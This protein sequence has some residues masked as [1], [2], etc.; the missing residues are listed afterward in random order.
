M[1]WDARAKAVYYRTYSRPKDDAGTEFENWDE[2]VG[3]SVVKHHTRL[4]TEAG[5]KPNLEEI[6][7][8][9]EL[10]GERKTLVSGRTLWLGGTDYSANRACSQ[11][12]CSFSVV[13]S[14]YSLVDACWLL[15]NGCLPPETPL[16]TRSGPKPIGDVIVGEEVLSYNY[17][18]DNYEFKPVTATHDVEVPQE[19]NIRLRCRYGQ[20]TTSV[21]HPILVRR[22]GVWKYAHAADLRVGDILRKVGFNGEVAL[23]LKAWF[24]GAFLGD[25]CS[26][27]TDI[28]SRRIRI[29]DDNEGVVK[30]FAEFIRQYSG[31]D[32]PVGTAER[33]DYQVPMWQVQKT[34]PQGNRLHTDWD[35]IVG[36]LPSRKTFVTAVPDWVKSSYDP[37]VFFSFLAG[38]LD[39]D[40]DIHKSK[41]QLST[42]SKTLAHDLLQLCPVFGIYPWLSEIDPQ[43]YTSSGYKPL[44]TMYRLV[45]TTNDVACWA[46]LA[47]N[48]KN[49]K[50]IEDYLATKARVRKDVVIPSDLIERELGYLEL[51][52]SQRHNFRYQVENN[53]SCETGY[54]VSRN[55]S[56]DHMAQFDQVVSIERDLDVPTT[57]KDLTVADNHSYVCGDGSYYVMHNCGYGFI[58]RPGTLHGF[59]RPIPNI[60]FVESTRD[61]ETKGRPNNIEIHPTADNGHAWYI[62]IGDS[63]EAWAKAIGKLFNPP[64]SVVNKLTID[65]SEIRGPGKRLKGYGWIC[66]GWQP[67]LKAIRKMVEILNN[68]AGDLLTEIDILDVV[69]HVGTILS[70]RRSAQIALLD[71]GHPRW[72]EFASAKKDFWEHDNHHRQQSNNSLVLWRKPPKAEIRK[73]M[74]MIWDNGGSEPGFVN[75]E[76]AR[77]RAP[78]FM[79]TNPCFTG[80]TQVYTADGRTKV[81]FDQLAAEGKDVPVFCLDKDDRVAVRMMRHPRKTGTQVRTVVVHFDGGFRVRCT[82][83]HKFRGR[84]G[85]EIEAKDLKGGE[86]ILFATRYEPSATDTRRSRPY[87]YVTLSAGGLLQCEH[88]EVAKFRYGIDDLTGLHVHHRD[89][90]RLNNS[91]DNLDI[92]KSSDHLS[93]HSHAEANPNFCGLSH[94]D[95]I[96]AGVDLATE[97]GRRFSTNE[98]KEYAEAHGW[99]QSFSKWRKAQFGNMAS[100]AVACAEA[101]GVEV[102]DG[103][104]PRCLKTVKKLRAEG[105]DAF[106]QDGDVVVRKAC[107]E[108]EKEFVMNHERREAVYCSQACNG[109]SQKRR[110]AADSAAGRQLREAQKAGRTAAFAAMEADGEAGR[111]LR[112]KHRAGQAA[113]F[114]ARSEVRRR[115]QLEVFTEL[116]NELQREPQKAEW[117]VRCKAK[118]VVTEMNRPSSPF[119][120]WRALKDAASVF[121]HRVVRIS[122]G[123]MADVYNGTVDEFHN[124]LVGGWDDGCTTRGLKVTRFA[125]VK[126]CGEIA[127]PKDGF[128]NLFTTNLSRF[129][130]K[131]AELRE[132]LYLAARANYRQTCVNLNDGVLSPTWNQTNQAL[133]LCGMSL[134]GIAMCPWVTDYDIRQMYKATVAGA[135]SMA[136]ELGLP[137]PKLITTIKPEG[138]RPL[139]GMLV[140]EQGLLTYKDLLRKHPKGQ[141]WAEMAEPINVEQEDGELRPALKTYANGKS[142]LLRINMS[143]GMYVT[144][145]PNHPWFVTAVVTKNDKGVAKYRPV[146]DFVPAEKIHS[147]MILDVVP[148]LY[149]KT[150]EHPLQAV[151]LTESDAFAADL[152]KMPAVT[153]PDLCWLLGFFWGN[154]SG[155]SAKEGKF[156][157]FAAT[158]DAQRTLV[159]VCR[160]LQE[161]FGLELDFGKP[162]ANRDD[163]RVVEFCSKHLGMW[164]DGQGVD[165]YLKNPEGAYVYKTNDRRALNYELPEAV[166][167]SSRESVVAFLA[168]LL[169]SDGCVSCDKNNEFHICWTTGSEKLAHN[170]QSVALA[171]GLKIGMSANRGGKN[172]Q[173]KKCVWL[174][175]MAMGTPA[176][177]YAVLAKHSEKLKYNNELYPEATDPTREPKRFF[178]TGVVKSV[179]EMDEEPTFDVEVDDN[180]YYF[181]EGGVK[182]HNTASKI[183]QCT[184]GIHKPLGRYIFNSINFS[185]HDPLVG[186]LTD[187]GYRKIAHPNDTNACLICFP[188]DFSGCEFDK[189]NGREVNRD[190]A[191]AQ[192]NRYRRWNTL[193]TEHNSS[194]TISWDIAEIEEIVDWLDNYW[195]DFVGVSW[196]RRADP[197]LTA[198]DLGY[199]YLPQ[200]VVT[201]ETYEKYKVTLR[202]VDWSNIHGIHEAT[203]Q[204][205]A[206]GVCPVK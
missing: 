19:E 27:K 91:P 187:A 139:D 140:T 94:E 66:N 135:Y 9:A 50:K 79:G 145:T 130:G 118:G 56:Y 20:I 205:C 7:R 65:F 76:A 197:T 198:A 62:G 163:V 181:A 32:C 154:G 89:K 82:P 102:Y 144:S 169:D 67:L 35:T 202:E 18:T 106:V 55:K 10:V 21:H 155:S 173:S 13:D 38:L 170:I 132:V 204:E 30:R 105:Y 193:W 6:N 26:N 115:Q 31:L 200:E 172:F 29:T 168:G 49:K 192:L 149:R 15:L 3:R 92:P 157:F 109:A 93:E 23:D 96:A 74:E 90:N 123:G 2:T 142:K 40:G 75:G 95:L 98:W 73:L 180:H 57:F 146:H 103:I 53:N 158:A 150:T 61:M 58:P 167:R 28:G 11:F 54:Y 25:G 141:Q 43:G 101:A 47:A 189:E 41:V 45:F 68:R 70:S 191:V 1:R 183:L 133:R 8:L 83:N 175:T 119:P 81:R 86:S 113:T 188:V 185:I 107:G 159:K 161:Q 69:N 129:R 60:E 143:Y 22:D 97:L 134:T 152:P 190:S 171:C 120:S 85:V 147:G 131:T 51:P 111:R 5:G 128:C 121:N 165:K 24:A 196:L 153:S 37:A 88:V 39:T 34:V 99:P 176:K 199:A 4:W 178:Q 72:K 166:R 122:D 160:I 156:K 127:L 59:I 164:L 126:N 110:W 184:E 203:D 33:D 36:T 116:V 186:M 52:S 63:A 177:D 194:N 17:K 195:H 12:N 44:Q 148:G 201:R 16:L 78:Y 100:F 179:E 112:E 48:T 151:L 138:C 108:C 42:S 87:R 14:V 77:N 80:D 136:I 46:Q 104:D 117:A 137:L 182:S 124:Y 174:C 162:S 125:S 84:D 64:T 206:G 71:Y 114:A